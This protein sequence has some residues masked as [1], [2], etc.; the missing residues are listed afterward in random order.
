M[1]LITFFL[2]FPEH[3]LCIFSIYCVLIPQ[4]ACELPEGRS[5]L[6]HQEILNTDFFD[7]QESQAPLFNA[8][9]LLCGLEALTQGGSEE[10]VTLKQTHMHAPVWLLTVS[11]FYRIKPKFLIKKFFFCLFAFSRAAPAAHRGSQARGLIG[12]V[13]AGLHQSHSNVGSEPCL[14]PTP[15]LMA[16]PDP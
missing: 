1:E 4:L 7:S 8:G 3:V 12:A 10:K 13:Y 5:Y 11:I 9:H 14:Q 16:T 6:I 2:G 15:Q